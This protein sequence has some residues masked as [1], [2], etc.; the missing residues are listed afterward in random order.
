VIRRTQARWRSNARATRTGSY[1]D[2]TVLK[3]F[4]EVSDNL[5]EL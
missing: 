1:G 5:D 2:A 3:K 4:G